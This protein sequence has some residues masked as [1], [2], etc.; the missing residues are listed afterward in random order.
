[1]S[2]LRSIILSDKEGIIVQL[3]VKGVSSDPRLKDV[4]RTTPLFVKIDYKIMH[5]IVCNILK[6][7]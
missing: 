5:E 4:G 2:T 7:T 3:I 6:K 1:M